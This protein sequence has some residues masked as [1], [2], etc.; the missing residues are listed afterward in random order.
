MQN[1]RKPGRFPKITLQQSKTQLNQV[2]QRKI[3]QNQVIFQK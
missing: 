3:Q 1:K 2:K